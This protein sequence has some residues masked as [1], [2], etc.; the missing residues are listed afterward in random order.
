MSMKE[1]IERGANMLFSE[2]FTL[3]NGPRPWEAI[4]GAYTPGKDSLIPSVELLSFVGKMALRSKELLNMAEDQLSNEGADGFEGWL[5]HTISA[6]LVET[7][8]KAPPNLSGEFEDTNTG[9]RDNLSALLLRE[10]LDAHLSELK[11]SESAKPQKKYLWEPFVDAVHKP[12]CLSQEKAA[13]FF[14]SRLTILSV[15]NGNTAPQGGLMA[16]T[17]EYFNGTPQAPAKLNEIVF[18]IMYWFDAIKEQ[19]GYNPSRTDMK[20]F[21]STV[22]PDLQG[23]DVTWT[24]AYERSGCFDRLRSGPRDKA[25]ITRLANKVISN[26]NQ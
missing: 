1:A 13:E 16:A 25:A 17:D 26:R 24:K 11:T 10:S 15:R 14:I 22:E 4:S 18:H 12:T 5:S 21:I 2:L 23:A 6:F 3:V 9:I 8:P 19:L 20:E 7:C